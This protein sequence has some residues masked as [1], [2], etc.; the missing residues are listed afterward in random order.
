ME[1]ILLEAVLRHME[2]GD[3][4]LDTQHGFSKGKSCLTNPT[5]FCDGVTPSLDKG[6]IMGVIPLDFSQ[7]FDT[8]LHDIRLSKL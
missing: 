6:R 3:M 7:A 2:D 5:A 1:Q 8:T 4:I